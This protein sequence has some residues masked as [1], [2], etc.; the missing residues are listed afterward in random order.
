MNNEV[1]QKTGRFSPRFHPVFFFTGKNHAIRFG[2]VE[3]LQ[4]R[5]SSLDALTS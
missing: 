4:A 2:S 5:R 1:L 3:N